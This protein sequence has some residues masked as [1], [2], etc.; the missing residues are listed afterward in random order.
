MKSFDEKRTK[1]YTI[2]DN[3]YKF[4]YH[5]IPEYR[6]VGKHC[7]PVM[8]RSL[9]WGFEYLAYMYAVLEKLYTVRP[10]SILDVGCG[11]GRL[12]SLIKSDC[13]HFHGLNKMKGIDISEKAIKLA[14][15]LNSEV[16]EVYHELDISDEKEEYDCVTCIETLEH[17]P[18]ELLEGVIRNL[19]RCVRTGG[20]VI[21]SVPTI[22]RPRSGKHFRHYSADVLLEELNSSQVR[23]QVESIEY[24]WK[25]NALKKYFRITDNRF[26]YLRFRALDNFLTKVNAKADEKSG[27]HMIVVLNKC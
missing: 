21:I 27:A 22:N 11:D 25:V 15:I 23:Y 14:G 26:L 4:P 6:K 8:E 16:E 1:E 18:D 20:K 3:Q 13:D 17:I 19:F 5:Y 24:I 9:R 2:Q 10:N 12:L 7:F